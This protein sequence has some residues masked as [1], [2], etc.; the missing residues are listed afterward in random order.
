MPSRV[1][2][3]YPNQHLEVVVRAYVYRW[4][5]GRKP[6]TTGLPN[7]R[8][9]MLPP[10]A[11]RIPCLPCYH[12]FCGHTAVRRDN[13]SGVVSRNRRLCMAHCPVAEHHSNSQ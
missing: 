13:G 2:D 7:V 5:P 11:L 10:P 12:I 3:T 4:R 6:G 8:R 1:G 9:P